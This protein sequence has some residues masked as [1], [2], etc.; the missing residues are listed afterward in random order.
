[1]MFKY[2]PHTD[3]DILAMKQVIGIAS[4]EEL[5]NDVPKEVLFRREYDIPYAM[6]EM[7]LRSYFANLAQKNAKT[8]CFAGLGVYDHY[9]PAVIDALVERQEFLTAYTPYQPEVSQGTLQYI[10]EFQSMIQMLTGLDAANA[11][12]YDGATATAEACFMAEAITRKKGILVS[13]TVNPYII[14]VL[15]TYCQPRGLDL[16]IVPEKDGVTDLEELKDM[17][18][19]DIA[20]VIGQKPN[21]LGIIE[22]M[23]PLAELA[24]Q[25]GA[26]FIENADLSALGVLKTPA[27]DG[28]DIAVGDCQALGIPMSFGGPGAGFMATVKKHVRKLPGRIVGISHDTDGKRAYVLTLQA[29]EAHPPGKSQ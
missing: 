1:M 12:M 7:E 14:D 21:F 4:L 2:F 10:F 28:A 16:K 29:R 8:V 27:E 19:D 22:E 11:S 26:V 15:R 3:E 23:A 20:A 6:S 13:E 9:N 5:F 24:H 17:L 25:N 18:G